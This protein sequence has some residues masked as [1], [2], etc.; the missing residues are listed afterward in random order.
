MLTQFTILSDITHPLTSGV[1]I[2]MLFSYVL[3]VA[4]GI[5]EKKKIEGARPETAAKPKHKTIVLNIQADCHGNF[6]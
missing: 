6:S 5:F 3:Y 1:V 2:H 4:V